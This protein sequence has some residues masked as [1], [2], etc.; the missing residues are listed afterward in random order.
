MSMGTVYARLDDKLRRFIAAQHLYFVASAPLAGDGLVNVSPKGYVDTFAVLD[1]VTVAYL[2][3]TGSGIETLAH[4]R[5]NGRLTVMFCSFDR[6]PKILRLQGRGEVVLASD[7]RWSDLVGR[8]GEHVGVRSIV[9][10]HIDR[11]ADSCGYAVPQYEF[12]GERDVLDADHARHGREY[13]ENYQRTR[14]ATSLD[15]LPALDPV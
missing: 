7:E 11:I 14:N 13:V 6:Q 9:V 4:L 15:G 2:D 1:D 3:L 5:E 12:T 8:F 10:L